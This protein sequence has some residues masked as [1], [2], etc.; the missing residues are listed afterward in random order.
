[1][2][3]LAQVLKRLGSDAA[4]VVHG[5]D[6]LDEITTTGPS[7][8]AQLKDGIVTVFEVTPE[9][10]GLPRASLDDLRG[11]DAQTNAAAIHALFD[12][13]RSPYRDIVLL[14]AAASLL[15]AGKAA[16]LTDGVALAAEAIDS[17]GARDRLRRLIAITNEAVS[18]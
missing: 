3:P 13:V 1:V 5:S 2:E 9:D 17:G 7:T 4:W 11:G 12:G 6:G 16:T 14:N 18:A 8:V 15:V 10:A